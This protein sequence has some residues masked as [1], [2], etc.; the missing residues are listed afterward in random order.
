MPKIMTGTVVRWK[1]EADQKK[2]AKKKTDVERGKYKPITFDSFQNIGVYVEDDEEPSV[3]IAKIIRK[4]IKGDEKLWDLYGQGF[5]QVY[6]VEQ[7]A[8]VTP[9]HIPWDDK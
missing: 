7:T 3:V 4:Y 8:E 1:E 2:E 9:P 5:L 6:D